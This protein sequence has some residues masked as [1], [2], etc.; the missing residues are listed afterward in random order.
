MLDSPSTISGLLMV[1]LTGVA[2]EPEYHPRATWGL[3]QQLSQVPGEHFDG[4]GIGLLFEVN[5]K[6]G[7]NGRSNQTLIGVIENQPPLIFQFRITFTKPALFQSGFYG[8]FGNVDP[9]AQDLFLFSAAH[10]K[11]P[12]WRYS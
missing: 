11:D 12:V 2:A 7:F 4:G 10:P 1:F 8:F 6:I 3:K 5:A 9:D